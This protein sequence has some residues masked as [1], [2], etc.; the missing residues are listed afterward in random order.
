MPEV[1]VD[2]NSILQAKKLCLSAEK[3]M[4]D[5]ISLLNKGVSSVLAG[6]KDQKAK[7]FEGIVNRC[8][9]SLKQPL[10]DLHRFYTYLQR[11]GKTLEEYN[12]ISFSNI[13]DSNCN[14]NSSLTMNSSHSLNIEACN[15]ALARDGNKMQMVDISNID[16]DDSS[17]D[18]FWSHHGRSEIEW[19]AGV[20]EY[21]NMM[22][23]YSNG[24]SIEQC[25]EDYPNT[26]AMFFGRDAIQLSSCDGA[27]V[28]SNGRHRIAMAQRLGIS[29]LP[30]IVY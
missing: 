2:S 10:D 16:I 7:E 30:A 29:F 3:E 14:V 11:L 26:A 4:K 15:N 23:S 13:G 8:I 18:D 27:F 22:Q 19:Q 21:L 9:V 17:D 5:T 1:S 25:Y 12:N 20:S 24:M 6:W 28:V